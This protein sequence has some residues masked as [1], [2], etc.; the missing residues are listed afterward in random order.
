MPVFSKVWGDGGNPLSMIALR[1]FSLVAVMATL[2]FSAEAGEAQTGP[3]SELDKLTAQ[4]VLARPSCRYDNTSD[5]CSFS[6][7]Y[8]EGDVALCP[9]T[10]I[11]TQCFVISARTCELIGG[12]TYEASDMMNGQTTRAHCW[13]DNDDLAR[14]T[15]KALTVQQAQRALTSLHL[16]SN[17]K[18]FVFR[19]LDSETRI[20]ALVQVASKLTTRALDA[21]LIKRDP[22]TRRISCVPKN[23]DLLSR[24]A[25]ERRTDDDVTFGVAQ[26]EWCAAATYCAMS[27]AVQP[28]N[29]ALQLLLDNFLKNVKNSEALRDHIMGLV[30][31]PNEARLDSLSAAASRPACVGRL[32]PNGIIQFE[33]PI[34]YRFPDRSVVEDVGEAR[35][36][37][38]ENA[39]AKMI[40]LIFDDFKTL[41]AGGPVPDV[42][43]TLQ[44]IEEALT[45]SAQ[46]L[47]IGAENDGSDNI[48]DEAALAGGFYVLAHLEWL[49][50]EYDLNLMDIAQ[51]EGVSL[52]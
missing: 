24:V 30:V 5:P 25:L 28:D 38:V 37:P 21:Y 46:M 29:L 31:A 48:V 7:E 52:P 32:A 1:R 15:H 36:V 11:F 17:E 34:R 8:A 6:M 13:I 39:I 42:S 22:A 35:D 43:V 19:G 47:R 33:A 23:V 14:R 9:A 12:Q 10:T 40:F 3:N 27:Y 16:L 51:S 50:A 41:Q 26:K 44:R 45:I 20:A 49:L 4:I 2:W 18:G